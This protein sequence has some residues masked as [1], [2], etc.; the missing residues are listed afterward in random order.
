MVINQKAPA[1]LDLKSGD[2]SAMGSAIT[3]VFMLV[4][5]YMI[6]WPNEN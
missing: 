3:A 2:V 5:L 6:D 1:A 4:P